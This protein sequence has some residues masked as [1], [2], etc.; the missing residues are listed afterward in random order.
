MHSKIKVLILISILLIASTLLSGAYLTFQPVQLSQPDKTQ[1]DLYASGDEYYNW[2]HDK[3]GYTV[4]ENDQGWYVY[5]ENSPDSELIFT[6][7]IVGKDIPASLNL[8]PGANI[9]PEKI[10]EI[11]K[12]A[13]QQLREIGNGRAPSTGNMNNISIFIRFSDQTEF[14]QNITNYTSIFN[15]TADN[16]L[17]SYF[18]EASYNALNIS[19]TFYPSHTTTVVSWQDSHPRAYYSPYSASNTI[20]FN[21]DTD[22]RNREFT[23]LVNAVTGVRSQIPSSLTIDADNDG[24]V[25]NVVFIIKGGTDGWAELL[26]PHRWSLYDRTVNINGKRVYDFNFQLSESLASSGVGVACHEMFHSLGAPD[27]YHYT[28]NGISPAGPWDIME[29][30]ANPPQHMG[31]YMKYKYG[32]WISSIPTISTSGT[33]TLNPLT[34]S[35]GQCF[36]INS[37]NSSSEYFVVEFRKKTGTFENSVPN[38]GMLIYR[39][40]PAYNGNA[41]GPPDEVYIFRPDGT[42]TANGTIRSAHF[43]SETGRTSF[44]NTTNPSGFLSNGNLGGISISSIGSSAG[45]T[46]SFQYNQSNVPLE[47]TAESSAGTVSLNWQ[48]PLS[49]TPSR[50]KVYRNDS[51]LSYST[52]LTYTDATVTVGNSYNYHV[53]AMLT[54]PTAESGASNSVNITVSNQIAVIIGTGTESGST[55]T[56]CPINVYYESLHGQSVYTKA[57]LN[58]LG[59]VGPI[60]ISQIGFNVTGLPNKAM[61]NYVVRMGH[62][63]ATNAANW[64]STGLTTVWTS[65]SY[66]P[67]SIGWNMLTLSTPFQWNGT[68]NLVVDTAFGLIGSWNS[69][70]TTEYTTVTNGYRFGRSDSANQINVFANGSTSN[71]RPNLKLSL[72]PNQSLISV[73]PNTF[74]YGNVV[75]GT[76]SNKQFT[77]QNSGTQ[78]LTG[79]I[80]TPTGYGVAQARTRLEEITLN[81]NKETRNLL[82]FSINAGTSKTYNLTFT[83]S[84]ITAYNGNVVIS[85]NAENTAN[86][87]LTVTGAGFIPPTIS[88]DNTTLSANLQ[89]GNEETQSF[90]ITNTGSQILTYQIIPSELSRNSEQITLSNNQ[91]D[92]NITGSTL[93]LNASEYSPGTTQNWTFTVYNASTDIEWLKHV[94][95]SFPTGITINSVTN[96]VGGSGGDLVPSPTSGN[97]ITIDWYGNSSYNWGVINGNQTATATVNVSINP[98]FNG[99]I[100]LPFQIVGDVYGS[101]PHT[102]SGTLTVAQAIPT[103]SWFSVQ[104]LSGTISAGQSQLITGHFSALNMPAGSYEALLTINSNDLANPS[105]E[106][107]ATMVVNPLIT[108]L[109]SPVIISTEKTLTGIKIQWLPVQNATSYNVYRSFNVDGAFTYL[110]GTTTQTEFVDPDLGN[111]PYAFYVIMATD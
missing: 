10:G 108:H 77:I 33:Y 50:Y 96:F 60:F 5:L 94:I 18:L 58:A 68:S 105:M 37:P 3:E 87:N 101:E 51:F 11:R 36:R 7:Y 56:A 38:S 73:N 85:S 34:S 40:N 70:G 15:G 46:I 6:D 65:S 78:T 83:P 88:V 44:N 26:W 86:L 16:N 93:T 103:I 81:S 104:P 107:S 12:K 29:N 13:Q 106:V 53:T 59:V 76:I 35:S 92:R 41:D 98:S 14:G 111:Y 20:G 32:H 55:S 74:S 8:T 102:L 82:S 22:R 91:A 100:S 63:S 31:A 27:L 109:D 71:N 89:V 30:N 54:N 17:Q 62:T 23:L 67:G 72:L 57:E 52:T 90:T 49:G 99:T 84:A 24:K 79:T 9:A 25:D 1:L 80:T 43:S 95:V 4:K 66:Q 2:L 28:E 69:S 75:V 48:A 47:L 21:G 19:T 39:I 61:P 97:G 64:S 45:N 110:C 42:Q